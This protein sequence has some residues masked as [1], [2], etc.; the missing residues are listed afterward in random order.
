MRIATIV[1]ARPQFVKASVVSRALRARHT[2]I[3]IHTGQHYDANMS[4][5]FFREL[6][7]PVP[8]RHLGVG[9]GPHGEQTGRMLAAV[10]AALLE[11][12]PDAVLVYG[13]TNSTLAGALAAVKLGMPVAH[14]EAGC[15]S[16]DRAMPEEINRVL[17]DH[18]STLL[19]CP[20]RSTV[21]NLAREGIT[22]GVHFV[23]DVMLDLC[24]ERLPEA[25]RSSTVLRDLGL[26]AGGYVVATVHRAANTDDHARLTSIV[27]ALGG[28]GDV[29]VFPVHPRTRAA[30][31]GT[32]LPSNVGLIDPLGY[33]D[34]LALV[35]GARLVATDSGGVQKEAF[36]VGTPCLTLRDR[37]EWPETLERG[38]NRLVDVDPGAIAR[39][40]N[41]PPP[42]TR[43]VADAF[44]DGHAAARIAARVESLP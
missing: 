40:L 14:V 8:D 20:T 9:S 27:T 18:A 41:S 16:Y 5:V 30:L 39:A 33:L 42:L 29:V 17:T 44:G 24:R 35:R 38:W 36:F 23:G 22:T 32:P 19:F 7:I 11:E 3:L 13:D 2:E 4:D 10:E 26:R 1:G 28:A 37:T 21:D 43:S 34:M 12:K 25:E 15:R 31:A 6:D